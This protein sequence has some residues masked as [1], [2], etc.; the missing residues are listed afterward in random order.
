MNKRKQNGGHSTKST[1]IDKR[2]NEY[3]NALQIAA[4]IDDVVKVI[5]AVLR[6]AVTEDDIPAAKLFLE[7][8]LG[9]PKES[10]DIY[11]T[12]DNVIAFNDMIKAIK[13]DSN[14]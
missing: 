9:K 5:Q 3:R 10:I 8:Y 2:K 7:Y 12:G 11:S 14:K 1:G 4:T 13:S 6:K